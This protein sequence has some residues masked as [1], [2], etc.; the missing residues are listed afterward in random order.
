MLLGE[1]RPPTKKRKLEQKEETSTSSSETT[2]PLP[3]ALVVSL[4]DEP[5][6]FYVPIEEY[7]KHRHLLKSLAL[8]D[9]DD[10][11][12]DSLEQKWKTLFECW[13]D[14]YTDF[15]DDIVDVTEQNI[16]IVKVVRL[17]NY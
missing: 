15:D 17:V 7:K 3:H 5:T 1:I 10:K 9:F 12:M 11:E 16:S 6:F 2:A 4:K 13:F 8:M 14:N